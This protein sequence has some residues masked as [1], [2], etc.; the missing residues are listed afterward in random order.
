MT[1]ETA[2]AHVGKTCGKGRLRR[3]S[4]RRR[5]SGMGSHLLRTVLLLLGLLPMQGAVDGDGTPSQARQAWMSQQQDAMLRC[6]GR[7]VGATGFGRW[8]SLRV[9]ATTAEGRNVHTVL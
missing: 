6:D 7:S 8:S 1:R 9:R 5:C 3:L 4:R 2:T